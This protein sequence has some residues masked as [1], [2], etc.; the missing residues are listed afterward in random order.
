MIRSS[1]AIS[2]EPFRRFL[3]RYVRELVR[4]RDEGEGLHL[5][6]NEGQESILQAQLQRVTLADKGTPNR[7]TTRWR[8]PPASTWIFRS[9][10][11]RD[12]LDE[13]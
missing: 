4:D 12:P 7:C 13:S 2:E 11:S 8:Q 5:F 1:G 9:P 6:G 10:S 3:D